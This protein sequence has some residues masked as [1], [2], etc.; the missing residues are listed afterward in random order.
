M[1]SL[2]LESLKYFNNNKKI[3]LQTH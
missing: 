1:Y 2:I 3:L